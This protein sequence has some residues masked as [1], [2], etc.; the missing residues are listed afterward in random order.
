MICEKICQTR[1]K[2][3]AIGNAAKLM[4]CHLMCRT[5]ANT[6]SL[7]FRMQASEFRLVAMSELVVQH[8]QPVGLQRY[9]DMSGAVFLTQLDLRESWIRLAW[10]IVRSLR[11][12][13]YGKGLKRT[14]ARPKRIYCAIRSQT[15]EYRR[16]F[17]CR[18]LDGTQY[19]TRSEERLFYQQV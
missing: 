4:L 7:T 3:F 6:C 15:D 1:Q 17:G 18:F 13:S 12:V 11:E 9:F 10:E 14:R 2:N 8:V 16:P 19:G 5:A